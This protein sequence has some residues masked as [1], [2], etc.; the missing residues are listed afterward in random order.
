MPGGVSLDP[1]QD[2]VGVGWTSPFLYITL[3]SD[4][5]GSFNSGHAPLTVPT[6]RIEVPD[7][8]QAEAAVGFPND[9]F[10]PVFPTD[11]DLGSKHAELEW[12]SEMV[13]ARRVEGINTFSS[14]MINWVIEPGRIFNRYKAE[15]FRAGPLFLPDAIEIG[16]YYGGSEE[17]TDGGAHA[18]LRWLLYP[19]GAR[20]HLSAAQTRM[21]D[22]WLAAGGSEPSVTNGEELFLD[23]SLLRDADG[24]P[25]DFL[26]GDTVEAELP[27]APVNRWHR[28]VW[29]YFNRGNRLLYPPAGAKP[30]IVDL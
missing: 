5:N 25:V 8:H 29:D 26:E 19:G 14:A 27:S 21:D 16:F 10:V 7:G 18:V 4:G 17:L 9:D 1:F 13:K 15:L 23:V 6:M 3:I 22:A 24:V 30:R 20:K 12:I 11:E 28:L 2:I